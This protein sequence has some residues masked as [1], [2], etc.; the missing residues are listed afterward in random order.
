MR[1]ILFA[2]LVGALALT[3]C[4]GVLASSSEAA[5]TTSVAQA[6]RVP[7]TIVATSLRPTAMHPLPTATPAP[8]ALPAVAFVQ[9]TQGQCCVQPFFSPDGTRVLF[10]D[11]P[12]PNAPAGIWSVATDRPLSPPEL[13]TDRLGPFSRDLSLALDL[14]NGRTVI[15]RLSDGTRWV[16]NNGGRIV[17]FSPDAAR[18]VWAVQ[19]EVGGFDVRRTELWVANADGSNPRSVATR[20]GGGALGWF[21][22]SRRLLIGGRLNR[23]GAQATLSILDVK[24]GSTR[25]LIRYERLRGPSI[26]PN[27]RWLAYFVSQSRDAAQDG[28]Y[29]LDLERPAAQPRRLNFFG[30]YRWRDGDRLLYVPLAP[31]VPSNELWQLDV[32]SGTAQQLIAASAHSPFKIANGDWDVSRD[33]S[34]VVFL[35]ARDRNL[36]LVTLP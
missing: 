10:L 8:T 12:S 24:D 19:Q 34:K 25:H 17:S 26:S 7:V 23:D 32:I 21:P 30:A 13:F 33:G 11:R 4:E 20:F 36:W 15:E 2:A 9:L 6:T 16:I 1:K 35:S 27:G 22:D 5:E 3:G 14:Q 28:M 29:M 31:G 18:I